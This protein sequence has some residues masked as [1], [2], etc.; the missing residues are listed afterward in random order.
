E[1]GNQWQIAV[2]YT[3]KNQGSSTAS[4]RWTDAIYVSGQPTFNSSATLLET[5]YSGSDVPSSLAAGASYSVHDVVTIPNTAAGARYLLVHTNVGAGSSSSQAETDATNNV[6]ALPITLTAPAADLAISNLAAPVAVE[7]G[8]GQSITVSW[9][10]TNQGSAAADSYWYDNVLVGNDAN[11]DRSATGLFGYSGNYQSQLPA[12]AS[13]VVTKSVAAPNVTPGAKQ[14]VFVT[15]TGDNQAETRK[16][17][18][19]IALPITFTQADVDL[20]VTAA[21]APAVAVAGA[22][23]SV[24]WSVKN[25]GGETAAGDWSDAVYLSDAPTFDGNAVMIDSFSGPASLA[26]GGT[27]SP[28]QTVTLPGSASGNKY[29]LFVTNYG[30][31]QGETNYANDVFAVPIALSSPD[32]KSTALTAPSTAILGDKISVSWTVTNQGSVTAPGG[33]S[34]AIYLSDTPGGNPFGAGDTY[35]GSFSHDASLAPGASYTQQQTMTLR[36]SAVGNRYLVVVANAYGEVGDADL[37]N[38]RFAVPIALSAPDLTV[39]AATAPASGVESDSIQVSWTVKNQGAVK[40]P[41]NWTDYVYVSSRPT[42]DGTATYLG[43]FNES[44]HTGLAAGASYTES[45]SVTLPAFAVGAQ[46]LLFITNQYGYQPESDTPGDYSSVAANNVFAVPITLSAPD[47]AVTA[48]AAPASAVVGNGVSIPISYTVKNQ[49]SVSADGSW[50]DYLYLSDRPVY[51]STAT[52]ITSLGY[53]SDPLAAGAS[54]S[55]AANVTVPNTAIGARYLLVVTNP[56]RSQGESDAAGSVGANNVYALPITFTAP[57]VDLTVTGA[58]APASVIAGDTFPVSFAVKNQGTD[59]AGANWTDQVYFSK[60]AV[61]DS[62]AVS[63]G[64][65]SAAQRPLPAGASYLQNQ[66]V[67]LSNVPIGAGYLLFVAN[68]SNDQSETDGANNAFAVPITVGAP[69]LAVTAASGPASAIVGNN[70]Q[71]A[72]SYTV[73]NVGSVPAHGSWYDALYV[74]DKPTFDNTATFVAHLEQNPP[75]LGPGASYSDNFN[76]PLK[77]VGAGARY[78]LF[79]ANAGQ[80]SYYSAQPEADG[81][82]GPGANN[83]FA[84]PITLTAPSVDLSVSNPSAPAGIVTGDSVSVSF[85]VTNQGNDTAGASWTDA[86]YFSTSATFDKN[87]ATL[88]ESFPAAQSPLA[89]G[90]EYDVSG[91]ISI[92]ELPSGA[93][94]LF[95]VA[96]FNG[97][98]AETDDGT[99]NVVSLPVT[100]GAPDLAVTAASAPSFAN[101]GDS[102]SVSWSVANQ[103]ASP[104]PAGWTDVIYLSNKPTFDYSA[105]YLGSFDESAHAGLAAGDSYN[106]S[107]TMTVPTS[108]FAGSLY[109]LVVTNAYGDQPESDGNG[110]YSPGANNVYALPIT[111]GA[112]D[113]AI[114]TATAPASAV[115]GNASSIAVSYTVANQGAVAASGSWSDNLYISD[116]PAYDSSA[117]YVTSLRYNYSGL[118]AGS[119]YTQNSNVT[120]PLTAT[121]ARY[122]LL[123]TNAYGSI[124]ESDAAGGVDANDVYALPITLSAPDVDLAPSNPTAP[125]SAT[126]GQNISVS[127]AVTNNGGEAAA[128]G[129]SDV[130][131]YSTKPTYDSSAVSVGYFYPSQVPLGAGASYTDSGNVTLS[132]SLP[133]GAGYLLFV[134]DAYQDQGESD[135]TNNVVSLPITLAAADLAT[136]AVTAPSSAALD[137]PISVSWTVTNQGSVAAPGNWIDAVYISSQPYWQYGATQIAT[138]NE[139]SQ[140][141]LSPGAN[142]TDTRNITI[143]SYLRSGDVYLIVRSDVYSSTGDTNRQNNFFATPIHLTASAADLTVSS[144]TAPATGV[145]GGSIAVSWTVTNQGTK[146]ASSNWTDAVYLSTKPTYDNTALFLDH[147]YAPPPASS[148]VTPG[149]S[150]TLNDNL[151]LPGSTTGAMYLLFITN[152][153][154]NQSES[155]ATNDVYALPITISAPDL[156][157]SAASAP[158]A[159]ALGQTISVSWTTANSGSAAAPAVW[160]DAVYVSSKNTFDNTATLIDSFYEGAQT[161]LAPGGSYS[162]TQNVNLPATGLGQRYLLFV[163]DAVH[164]QP[165][166]SEA[167]NVYAVPITLAAP[168]LTVSG[169]AAPAAADL[170]SPIS[171]SWTVQNSSAVAAPAAW[172]D[173]VYVSS[174]PTLD[175]TATLVAQF[176]ES[177]QAGLAAGASYTDSQSIAL[178]STAIGQRYLLFVTDMDQGQPETNAANDVYALPITLSGADLTVASATAPSI[179][180]IG[181]TI[182]LNWTVKNQGN[183]AA[184]ASWTDGIYLSNTNVLDGSAVYVGDFPAGAAPLAAGASYTLSQSVTIPNTSLGSRF[185]LIVADAGQQQAESSEFNNTLALPIQ[186]AQVDLAAGNAAAPASANF[187]DTISVSWTATNAGS[188]AINQAWSDRIYLS[189]TSTL[190]VNTARLL[191]TVGES[192]RAPLGAGA[193]YTQLA[194]VTLPLDATTTPGSYYVFVVVD[195]LNQASET[196]ETNNAVSQAITLGL[197][198]LPEL[199]PT[200]LIV[201]ASGLTG[202]GFNVSWTDQNQGAATATGPW[203]DYVW[204]STSNTLDNNARFLGRFTYSDSLDP[205]QAVTR[206][207]HFNLPGAA[208]QYYIIVRADADSAINE[209]PNAAHSTA[210]SATTID[211]QTTPLPDLVVSAITPPGDGVLSGMTVPVTYTVT[212]NGNAPTQAP[213]WYDAVFIS[214]TPDLTLTGNDF[215]DGF[216]IMVQPLGVPVFAENASYL[217]PGESY[218]QTVNVPLPVSAAGPWYV[219]VVTNRS[220]THTPLDN[221]I[222]TG[223]VRES[224]S[225]NDLTRSAAFNV[226][227]APTPD[228]AVTRVQAPTQAFSGQTMNLSWTVT[229]QGPGI[230]IGQPLHVGFA[231]T[232]PNVPATPAQSTWQESVYLSTTQSIDASAVL[233]QTFTHNGA[234]GPGDSFTETESVKLPVGVSGQYYL[235][236]QQDPSKQIFEAGLTANNVLSTSATTN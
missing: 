84:V 221:F 69:D 34:D 103:G 60:S 113:L 118:A 164:D 6:F 102:I 111:I 160:Y 38:N 205:G 189:S 29:L 176:D 157:V 141:G 39:T 210:T 125:A 115:V 44:A 124:S 83:V 183:A 1:V 42:Y 78:L 94:Y 177:V 52:Y 61:L 62:S 36:A 109:L 233:L 188:T 219:Y 155:D 180:A 89:G 178:P 166:T 68:R 187:G 12:G 128:A 197:P 214:Q 22:A 202:Q 212:N 104:A 95:F 136:T 101:T 171:V 211:V 2:D 134:V 51:D 169:A 86:V 58:T 174:V 72:V 200:N 70:Q 148:P 82:N 48:A 129:W 55:G 27:Y 79:V 77:T 114:T 194:Q 147:L 11:Y 223:A 105:R 96:N 46:Y 32:L 224:D 64:G 143:P 229:N 20:T 163:A 57:N 186:L 45:Q 107:Q 225:I 232:Q 198:A 130:V 168:D 92:P 139:S 230:A 231:P 142:Y 54:Y 182:D 218:S 53:H 108:G 81:Q 150:Y 153:N 207:Q 170:G 120:L 228:V 21:T 35:V 99:D 4:G 154:H 93:G 100:V 156:T 127:F 49:G 74:S 152:S 31:T 7:A 15:D 206:T 235:I 85:K 167:N 126:V 8:N 132:P 185:L 227:L 91:T 121:G 123:V 116:K 14:L 23:I 216:N 175:G 172:H 112:P 162:E 146:D 65:F 30:R 203:Q 181:S 144:A 87:Q 5:L 217:A 80:G 71:L 236:V 220:F 140:S 50:S 204:I 98:Q 149:A 119:S 110:Y 19:L 234:L 165:E 13:Y 16:S 215:T 173:A 191:A 97:D 192:G 56:Y 213:L 41:A 88:L 190:D 24:S 76:V 67:T 122:L 106:D 33:W 59:A 199:V 201:P 158:A 179:A 222:D 135:K 208:G 161:D 209:G 138:F 40:A 193:S 196:N 137:S 9:K 28:V 66:S 151:Y 133:T 131:Y 25:Q 63:V 75:A 184:Q 145:L 10:V 3:A 37:A 226:T 90:A 17:N 26:A 117:E 159:A 73:Q 195:G 43:S 18:N 47:L